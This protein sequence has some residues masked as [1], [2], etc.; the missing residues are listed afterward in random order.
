MLSISDAGTADDSDASAVPPSDVEVGVSYLLSSFPFSPPTPGFIEPRLILVN[1]LYAIVHDRTKVDVELSRLRQDGSIRMARMTALGVDDYAFMLT[2][3][4][5]SIVQSI[6]ATKR[7]A[8]ALS[9]PFAAQ[10]T[11]EASEEDSAA[12]AAV[13]LLAPNSRAIKRRRSAID[14]TGAAKKQASE[15]SEAPRSPSPPA[16]S[17][18]PSAAAPPP[19]P[20]SELRQPPLSPLSAQQAAAARAASSLSPSS[21]QFPLASSPVPLPDDKENGSPASASSVSSAAIRL[22]DEIAVLSAVLSSLLPSC[23]ELSI[24]GSL[25]LALVTPVSSFSPP[26]AMSADDVVSVLFHYQLLS[27][28][29][30]AASSSA[31]AASASYLLVLPHTGHIVKEVLAAR[32]EIARLLAASRYGE[33]RKSELEGRVRLRRS[34]RGVR[35]HMI[36]MLGAGRLLEVDTTKGTLLRINTEMTRVGRQRRGGH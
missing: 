34:E 26:F 9:T 8:L 14:R 23:N 35:W 31:S 15:G 33:M 11:E 24:S 1:Q 17:S 2:A 27:T 36:E 21:F 22:R 6:I 12:S 28:S 5:V 25:L 18:P 3:D 19:P 13:S 10:I 29:P 4:Y 16:A 20:S 32:E 30:S 7:K